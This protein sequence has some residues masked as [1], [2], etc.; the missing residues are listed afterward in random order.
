M[1]PKK[2]KVQLAAARN[3]KSLKAKNVAN[4]TWFRI[5]DDDDDNELSDCYNSDDDWHD[6]EFENNFE[7]T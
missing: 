7:K 5:I 4:K 6:D 2:Q 1:P 3:S